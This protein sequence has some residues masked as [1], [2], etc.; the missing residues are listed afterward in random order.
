MVISCINKWNY[1][2]FC[3][4]FSRFLSSYVIFPETAIK[5]K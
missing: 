5:N 3:Y 1:L 4:I 2:L